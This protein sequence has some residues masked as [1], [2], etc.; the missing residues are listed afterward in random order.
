MF[1]GPVEQSKPWDTK[2]IDGVSRFLRK[3]WKL[4]FDDKGVFLVSE[5]KPSAGEL[6]TLHKLIGKVEEDIE[7]FSYNTSVSAFMIAVNE[8]SDMKCNKRA[9]LEK[10]VVLLSPFA[11][12]LCEELWHLLGNERSVSFAPFPCYDASLTVEDEVEYPVSF[13]GK[14]RFKINLPRSMS[15]EDVRK[16]VI[17]YKDTVR[18]LNGRQIRKIIVVPGRIVNVVC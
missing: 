10:V 18:Y 8:L 12:H 14:T 15:Q 6:K 16:E 13:N 17:E 4:F 2:G 5:E 9:V 1:L 11:P 7:A 3:F